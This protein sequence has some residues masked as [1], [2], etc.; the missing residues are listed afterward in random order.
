MET[1]T[2]QLAPMSVRNSS[3]RLSLLLGIVSFLGGLIFTAIPAIILGLLALR[4]IRAS[5]GKQHG[6]NMAII[7]LGLGYAMSIAFLLVAGFII[8]QGWD[9]WVYVWQISFGSVVPLL[10]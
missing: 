3:A 2:Q 6:E 4:Q 7:G 8:Y 1:T 10:F 9:I 5:Q